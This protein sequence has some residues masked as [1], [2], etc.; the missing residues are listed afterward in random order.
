MEISNVKDLIEMDGKI[1]NRFIELEEIRKRTCPSG[2]DEE[3]F[4]RSKGGHI[5]SFIKKIR[6]DCALIILHDLKEN[7]PEFFENFTALA[8]ELFCKKLLGFSVAKKDILRLVNKDKKPLTQNK[9]NIS[10]FVNR[11]YEENFKA[12][13]YKKELR[14]FISIK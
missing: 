5:A 4:R 12:C 2:V 6:R 14:R 3:L 9:K 1:K 11:F 8:Y 13:N 10:E 7:N